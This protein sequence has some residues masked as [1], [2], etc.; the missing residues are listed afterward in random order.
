M[1]RWCCGGLDDHRVLT[2]LYIG[3]GVG[4]QRGWSVLQIGF[5]DYYDKSILSYH[6]CDGDGYPWYIIISKLVVA[7][8]PH[9]LPPRSSSIDGL[10]IWSGEARAHISNTLVCLPNLLCLLKKPEVNQRDH[11]PLKFYTKS[12]FFLVQ[13]SQQV[14]TL[15]DHNNFHN[16]KI[17][18]LGHSE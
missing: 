3:R 16:L 15:E 2:P 5:W 4:L 1:R 9:R 17:V 6:S 18:W 14:G 11:L 8:S 10:D 12:N 13:I 7:P